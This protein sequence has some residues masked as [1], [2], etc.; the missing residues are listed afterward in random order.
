M[1]LFVIAWMGALGW[2]GRHQLPGLHP[3]AFNLLQVGLISLGLLAL[4]T[5]LEIVDSS[6]VDLRWFKARSGPDLPAPGFVSVSIWWYRLC[7]LLWALWLVSALLRWL[8]WGWEQFSFGGCFRRKPGP[9]EK[10]EQPG[11]TQAT[12]PPLPPKS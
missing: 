4:G 5:L 2:R 11:E 7:M 10:P 8:K 12:P 1:A 3:Y 9:L 6:A